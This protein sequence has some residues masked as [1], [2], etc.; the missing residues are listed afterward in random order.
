VDF[1]H[2]GLTGG[3]HRSDRSDDTCQFWVRTYTLCFCSVCAEKSVKTLCLCFVYVVV[4]WFL[5]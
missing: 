4:G 3:T 2:T 5:H 1:N